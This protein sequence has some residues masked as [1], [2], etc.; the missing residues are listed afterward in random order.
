M[1]Y[2]GLIHWVCYV[3]LRHQ[4]CD[5]VPQEWIVRSTQR[6]DLPGDL[7][8]RLAELPHDVR[9]RTSGEIREFAKRLDV[10]PR[11]AYRKSVDVTFASCHD[12]PLGVEVLRAPSPM[13]LADTTAATWSRP[14]LSFAAYPLWFARC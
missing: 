8:L 10:F 11:K 3:G 1:A 7:K 4:S 2:C 13:S 6:E 12:G 14:E 5:R 9:D